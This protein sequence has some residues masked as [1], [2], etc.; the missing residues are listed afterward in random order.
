MKRSPLKKAKYNLW[1]EFSLFIRNRDKGICITCGK[2]GLSGHNYH[3]GHFIPN[4]IGGLALRYREDNVHGQCYHCNINLGGWGERYAEVM[5]K[6]YG[7]DYVE[8]LRQ[9]KYKVV[10]W[11]LEDYKIKTEYYKKVNAQGVN[12]KKNT[13]KAE[14]K[15][16]W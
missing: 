6:K 10:K 11:T 2:S 7:R 9:L 12:N 14:D 8:N 5:E 1:K 4:A 16:I 15:Y 3:A 13:R